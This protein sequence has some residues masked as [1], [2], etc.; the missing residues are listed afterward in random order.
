MAPLDL[1]D[2]TCEWIPMEDGLD[3]VYTGPLEDITV[4][5]IS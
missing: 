3:T 2:P 5:S 4:R 1:E